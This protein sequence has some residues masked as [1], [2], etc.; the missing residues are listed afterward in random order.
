[1]KGRQLW[2]V[3]SV[4]ASISVLLYNCAAHVVLP[5]NCT[6]IST[7][8]IPND[9]STISSSEGEDTCYC[10]EGEATYYYCQ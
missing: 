3:D 1:M 8:T 2:L 9:K 5:L 6:K 7:I 4:T 10:R